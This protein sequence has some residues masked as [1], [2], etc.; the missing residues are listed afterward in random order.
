MDKSKTDNW[1][2]WW[3]KTRSSQWGKKYFTVG[4][5][6]QMF[7]IWQNQKKS[8]L[9]RLEKVENENKQLNEFIEELNHTHYE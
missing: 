8:L 6:K 4:D 7:N 1:N 9:L 2:H 5:V 3:K